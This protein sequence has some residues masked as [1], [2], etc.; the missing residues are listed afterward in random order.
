MN[1]KTQPLDNIGVIIQAQDQQIS[2]IHQLPIQDLEEEILRS[3]LVL[4]RGF[5]PTNDKEMES[6]A[7]KLGPLLA[8]DFGYVLDLKIQQD[9][10]NHIFSRG[11]VELHWDGAF[12]N[13]TPRYNFFQCLESSASS[14]GGETI[15]LN[16]TRLLDSLPQDT[17]EELQS[18]SVSYST[19]KVAHYGGDI[20]VPLLSQHP[21]TQQMRIQFVEPFNEDN[22]DVNPVQALV[23]GLEKSKSDEFLH[24]MIQLCYQSQYIYNHVWEKGDYLLVDNHTML[25]GRRRFQSEGLSRH[26]KRVHIL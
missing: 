8:W 15:F 4:L 10:A 3:G 26:L 13:E 7:Q 5:N 24:Q 22:Q 2:D 11:R 9:P 23:S 6:F 1:M 12:A 18:K 14:G 17:F 25:H 19:K 21:A 20:H 16:T